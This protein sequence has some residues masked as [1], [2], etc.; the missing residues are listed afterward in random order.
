MLSAKVQ[1]PNDKENPKKKTG[2]LLQFLTGLYQKH[3]EGDPE[4]VV[5]GTVMS[6]AGN[7]VDGTASTSFPQPS[8]LHNSVAQFDH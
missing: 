8:L 3:P 4:G 1:V 6:I 2:Q 5:G 7:T